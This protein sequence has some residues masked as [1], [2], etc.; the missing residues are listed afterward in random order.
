MSDKPLQTR[1]IVSNMIMADVAGGAVAGCGLQ[2][3]A[4]RIKS[5]NTASTNPGGL[6]LTDAIKSPLEYEREFAA[7]MKAHSISFSDSLEFAR[8]LQNY[9]A[10][11]MYI[12]EHNAENAWTG[13]TL[14]HNEFSHMSFDEFK[15]KMTGLV[16]PDR[17][18]EQRLASRVDGLYTNV[19]T[20]EAV[21]WEDK[22]GVTPVKNQGMC[23][24]CWAFS[25]TGAVEGAA[26]VTSGKLVNLSEQELMDCDHNGDMGCSGG[27]MDHAFAWIEENGGLC[28]EAD[29]EYKGKA[30]MCRK[31]ED[32]V[33]VTGF[34]D[35][36][37]QDEHA[38]RVAVAQQPVSVAIEAD[39]KAFQFY[40]SGV[41]NLTCG[42]KLD[43]GVLAVGYGSENG[44]KFWK[45]KNSWGSTWGEQGYIRL[46]REE[47]GPAGQCGIASVPSYPFATVIS[48]DENTEDTEETPRFDSVDYPLNSF[49]AEDA[50]Y[51]PPVNLADL[52][53]SAKIKQ[54]GDV[55]SSEIH[56]AHLEVA[57][58]SPQRGQ[59][60]SIFGS[61]HAK[62]D[63]KSA[64]FKL[65]VRLAGTPVFGHTGEMCGDTH[66]PLPLDLGHID[67]HGFTCPMK[68]GDSID[69][70]VEV[71]LP[72]IAPAGN[73]EIQLV[74]DDTDDEDS[75]LLFCVNVELDLTNAEG[76]SKKTR[77]YEPLS[78]M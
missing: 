33:K 44:Q 69:L 28:S 52:F 74:S 40:K 62:R 32:V 15:Y 57:P 73:Y 26:F 59:P 65:A 56:F 75:S 8:R 23:G 71:N 60:V 67:V 3:V 4:T 50:D 30:E 41:F 35:V 20:P 43:H 21:D 10:N 6:A 16:L 22:G 53:S 70:K 31:C 25:T 34:Q 42:T 39:Q 27:L 76:T 61:G 5:S 2:A 48:E 47:N 38:L 78:F 13:V 14:G 66:I 68:K 46:A 18:V 72:I 58:T 9:I 24:S 63:V 12:L 7:W 54:C 45:V 29:Y 1:S 77:V 51:L 17:Y 49:S 11:D 37:A 55:S 64:D 36:N 19:E